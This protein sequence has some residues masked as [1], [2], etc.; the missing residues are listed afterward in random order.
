M[1]GCTHWQ[2]GL[3]LGSGTDQLVQMQE[4]PPEAGLDGPGHQLAGRSG[5]DNR[6]KSSQEPG[7]G[8]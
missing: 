3:E 6:E 5:T 7:Q 1:A 8:Q 2:K 4:E